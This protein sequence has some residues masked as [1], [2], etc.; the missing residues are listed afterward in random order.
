[1]TVFCSQMQKGD[2][3]NATKNKRLGKDEITK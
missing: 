3:G 1:M 2:A